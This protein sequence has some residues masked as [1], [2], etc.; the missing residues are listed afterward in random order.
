MN[1]KNKK[2]ALVGLGLATLFFLPKGSNAKNGSGTAPSSGGTGGAE[3][4]LTESFLDLRG[5]PLS[6]QNN[7]PGSIKF[8]FSNNWDGKILFAQNTNKVFEQF[9]TL[10]YGTRALIKL[11]R[12]YIVRDSRNTPKKIIEHWDLA[13]PSYTSF[14]VNETGF[15]ENQVL[16]GDKATLKKLA[17]A[18][19]RF[20]VGSEFLTDARFEAGYSL[21]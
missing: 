8:E 10:A 13:N 5:Y 21:L 14:L 3:G 4:S 2:A 11:L 12:N 16:Q 9:E 6:V 19:A 15:A 7:N 1:L 20:E 18:I 17:Q